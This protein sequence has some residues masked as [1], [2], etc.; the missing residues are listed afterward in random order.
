MED[1]ASTNLEDSASIDGDLDDE[2]SYVDDFDNDL[3]G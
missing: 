2:T 1:N 3:F